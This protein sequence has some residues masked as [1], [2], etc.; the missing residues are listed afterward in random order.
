VP[1]SREWLTPRLS[2]RAVPRS[3]D[4]HS[5]KVIPELLPSV[6]P[7]L[8]DSAE[9]VPDERLVPLLLV[10]ESSRVSMMR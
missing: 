3:P 8:S 9:V 5:P 10:V 1:R 7:E 4:W 2:V 6:T